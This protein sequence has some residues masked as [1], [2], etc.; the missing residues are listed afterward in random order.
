M[1][2]TKSCHVLQRHLGCKTPAVGTKVYKRPLSCAVWLPRVLCLSQLL[3]SYSVYGAEGFEFQCL[4]I[5]SHRTS[6]K[7]TTTPLAHPFHDRLAFHPKFL[8]PKPDYIPWD[9]FGGTDRVQ[10]GFPQAGQPDRPLLHVGLPKIRGAFSG[11]PITRTQF[12]GVLITRREIP[13][14]LNTCKLGSRIT[15]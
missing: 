2:I 7:Q 14:E 8:N 1:G 6:A 3:A 13:A 10:F 9:L 4:P 5:S 15:R 12:W 11:V